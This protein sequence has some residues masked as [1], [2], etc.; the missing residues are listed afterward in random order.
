MA[1][2]ASEDQIAAD[3][4][5]ARRLQAEEGGPML[6]FNAAAPLIP[7]PSRP[8]QQNL[9]QEVTDAQL[10]SPRVL[11]VF[12]IL[13][14][15]E[16][17]ASIIILDYNWDKSCDKQLKLWL[18][19]FSSRILISAPIRIY[20][21]IKHRARQPINQSIVQLE[22]TV[23]VCT[24]IWFI[25]GQAWVYSSSTCSSTAPSLYIYCLVLI[26]I[27]YV[28]LALPLLVL[29]GLCICLPCVLV[30]LRFMGDGRAGASDSDIDNL[31]KKRFDANVNPNREGDRGSCVVCMN[32][33]EDGEELRVLPVLMS[34]TCS[35][36]IAG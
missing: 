14:L 36:W 33:F 28:S 16:F 23:K 35:V 26:V 34:F 29:L 20:Y 8:V 22:R 2:F 27:V 25:F 1:S 24:F 4:A 30:L 10:Q 11:A 32:D 18:L 13:W 7:P 6:R 9:A 12:C 15:A 31:P 3:E 5:L 21:F 19:V 17:V